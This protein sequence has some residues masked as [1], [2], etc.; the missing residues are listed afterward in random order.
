[1]SSPQP[2][3]CD[4][5]SVPQPLCSFALCA[6]LSDQFSDLVRKVRVAFLVGIRKISIGIGS[7]QCRG[8][9]S[10]QSEVELSASER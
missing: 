3:L 8:G 5:V 1:M 9:R 2:E 4:Q 6:H 7:F 10:I